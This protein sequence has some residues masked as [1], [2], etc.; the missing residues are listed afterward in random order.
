MEVTLDRLDMVFTIPTRTVDV[1]IR[2]LR[3]GGRQGGHHKAWVVASGHHFRFEDDPP[4]LAPGPCSIG[5]LGI[6][7]AAVWRTGVM[8]LRQSGPLLVQLACLL[9]DGC[10]VAEQDR[11]AGQ[12]EDKIDQVSMGQHF[13]H[14]RCGEMAIPTD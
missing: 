8:G 5:K 9:H 7:A 12:A 2:L 1:L 14:L 13:D 3:R 11:I 4:G 6:Q 10:G